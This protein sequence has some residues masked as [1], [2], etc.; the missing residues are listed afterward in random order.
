MFLSIDST[1]QYVKVRIKQ[2]TRNA[3]KESATNKGTKRRLKPPDSCSKRVKVQLNQSKNRKYEPEF[4]EAMKMLGDHLISMQG[5]EEKKRVSGEKRNL[6][7][8]E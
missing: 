2:L 1:E 8:G 6:K 4:V 3:Q 5:K 7:M